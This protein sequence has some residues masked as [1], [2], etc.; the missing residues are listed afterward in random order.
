MPTDLTPDE[1]AN[2][3]SAL[4]FIFRQCGD[5]WRTAAQAIGSKQSTIKS[6]T[7]CAVAPGAGL[8]LRIARALGVPVDDVL[9]GRYPPKD[10]CHHCGQAIGASP[11]VIPDLAVR[12]A[13]DS[14]RST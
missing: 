4:R 13:A 5:S 12:A 8:A 10:V 11:R 3:R 1:Q 9:Q 7:N 2:V 6:V 14:A